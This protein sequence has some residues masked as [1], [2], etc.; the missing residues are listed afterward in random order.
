LGAGNF[1]GE[2]ALLTGAIRTADI[3]ALTQTRLIEITRSDFEPL[4]KAHPEIFQLVDKVSH[5]RKADTE[6]QKILSQLPPEPVKDPW[7]KV[8]LKKVRHFFMELIKRPTE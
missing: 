4:L 8:Y 2:M 5:S 3:I 1:F 6:T 7:Y